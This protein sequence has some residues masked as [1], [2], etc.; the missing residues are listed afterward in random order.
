LRGILVEY[1]ENNEDLFRLR[2]KEAKERRKEKLEN[3]RLNLK[4]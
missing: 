2:R 4:H 3:K 1:E